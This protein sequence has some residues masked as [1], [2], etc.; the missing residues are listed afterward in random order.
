MK[1]KQGGF[2]Q[3]IIIIIIALVIMKFLGITLS[4]VFNWFLAF[5]RSV[6]R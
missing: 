1:N 4:G 2:L 5:F 3:V 6:L